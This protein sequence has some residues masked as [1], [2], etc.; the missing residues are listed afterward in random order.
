MMAEHYEFVAMSSCILMRTLGQG[1]NLISKPHESVYLPF[2][3]ITKANQQIEVATVFTHL[4][5]NNKSSETV[6]DQ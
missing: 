1:L 3:V 4:D 6:M 2:C 5:I